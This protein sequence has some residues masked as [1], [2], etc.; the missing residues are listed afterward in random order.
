MILIGPGDT[1]PIVGQV[2]L[3][4]GDINDGNIYTEELAQRVRGWQR[5]QGRE[6]TGLLESDDIR[7][8][9]GNARKPF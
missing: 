6:V 4:L 3:K 1:H 7:I 2:K 8:L 5:T 9:F